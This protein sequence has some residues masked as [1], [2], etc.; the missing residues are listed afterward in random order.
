M[1]LHKF[2]RQWCIWPE[3]CIGN[4]QTAPQAKRW[5]KVIG[6]VPHEHCLFKVFYYQVEL[7][8][9][10]DINGCVNNEISQLVSWNRL[11]YY[12]LVNRVGDNWQVAVWF[13]NPQNAQYSQEVTHCIPAMVYEFGRVP[14]SQEGI[15]VYSEKAKE[16]E[17]SWALKWAD[18]KVIEQLFPLHSSLHRKKVHEQMQSNDSLIYANSVDHE[19]FDG[20]TITPLSLHPKNNIL[21]RAKCSNHFDLDNPWM[22]WRTMLASS[23]VFLLYMILDA[24]LIGYQQSS[25]DQQLTQVQQSTLR[26]QNMRSQFSE[27]E[28]FLEQYSRAKARQQA[29]V[30]LI[31]SLTQKLAKDIVISRMD[32]QQTKV[33]L[34]GSLFDTS[35]L[36]DNLSSIS[37]VKSAKLLG[38]VTPTNDDRQE[39]RVELTMDEA[40]LWKD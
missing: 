26:L 18:G 17:L 16:D 25:V 33:V 23:I 1:V 40:Y 8:S 35:A 30:K 28:K 7:I 34:E 4:P 10:N 31:E 14:S 32:Y 9:S 3:D 15:L 37:G 12:Y 24:A 19:L 22:F 29:P 39:F 20:I 5:D 11:A 36:L 38:E 13:W 2:Q 6:L 21:K 27:S